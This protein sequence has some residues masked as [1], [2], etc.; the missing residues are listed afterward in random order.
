MVFTSMYIQCVAGGMPRV[1]WVLL[2]SR[3]MGV[4]HS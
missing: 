2:L 3:V 4:A 1:Y